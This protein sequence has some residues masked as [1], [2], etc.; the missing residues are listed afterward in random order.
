[1]VFGFRVIDSSTVVASLI[2][3]CKRSTVVHVDYNKML[4]PRIGIVLDMPD[5]HGN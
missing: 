5:Y 2:I 3:D 1:M 4:S